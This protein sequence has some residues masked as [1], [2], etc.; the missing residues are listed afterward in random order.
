MT[1]HVVGAGLAGLAAAVRLADAGAAV[2]LHDKVRAAGGRC[3]SFY[4]P[5]FG[6]TID[7]GIHMAF[8]GYRHLNA[9]LGDI[10]APDALTGPRSASC[11]FVDTHQ[12]TEWTVGPIA[13]W[14]PWWLGASRIPGSR[15]A[16]YLALLR[17]ALAGPQA[18]VASIMPR[19]GASRR[20]FWEPMCVAALNTMPEE[21]HAGLLWSV[22]RDILMSG[23]AAY[24]PRFA[25]RDLSSDLV[26]PAL[27]RLSQRG[28]DI[29][30]GHR[31]AGATIENQRIAALHFGDGTLP[32]RAD[33]AVVLA[34]P[35][36][37]ARR[38][39]P[40]LQVPQASRAIVSAHFLLSR[41]VAPDPALTCVIDS[42]SLWMVT[43][44]EVA[45]VTVGAADDLAALP[46][47]AAARRLW[48]SAAVALGHDPSVLPPHR[49][50]R[51]RDGTFA[52][53][54][55]EEVRR[56]GTRTAWRNLFLAGDWTRTDA[57][58][59]VQGAVLSGH[60]AAAAVLE[61]R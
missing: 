6:R 32:M 27:R 42:R 19:R 13:R 36:A 21:A 3:R 41:P 47:A 2:V 44:G 25:R 33:D 48:A 1:I 34:V 49:I 9:Y 38:I 12:K 59:T 5:R 24:R 30:L 54:P 46:E 37:A 11:R 57:P 39:V 7:Y 40:G 60:R 31:L 17:L 15:P 50:L 8:P 10:D 56:P 22:F 16:D 20:R 35:P 29:R 26:A 61:A 43:R 28:A 53:T 51:A 58:A 52:Q 23:E 45:A 14:L 18:T 4:D 55:A